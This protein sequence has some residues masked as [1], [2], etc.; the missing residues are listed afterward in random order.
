MDIFK[1]LKVIDLSTVLAGPSVATFFAELGAQ[2]IKIE[3]SKTADVTRSWKLP[4][5]EPNSTVSAYFSSV[6]YQKSYCSLDL[7]VEHDRNEFFNIVKDADLL[8]SNFKKGDEERLG[9]P[10]SIIRS[11]N[12]TLLWGKI[13][14]YGN[15]SDRVAYDLILQAETGYM[16]MNGEEDGLPV[17][18]PV[19]M[20]D[21]LAAH[22]LKEALLIAL[23]SREKTGEGS[24]VTVSLYDAA[25]SSLINQASNYLMESHIPQRLGSLHPN[26]AP[27]GELFLT[28]DD[29]WI[30]FAIGSDNHFQKLCDFLNISELVEDERFFSNHSRVKNR[31]ALAEFIQDKVKTK[32]ANQILEEMHFLHVPAASI[33]TLNEVFQDPQALKMVREE[34]IDGKDTK[35]VS[36]IAFKWISK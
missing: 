25:I 12:P 19:A 2:V 26:I 7:K 35:R 27:Y 21:V 28:K 32:T 8:I 34:K 16:S 31:V 11:I 20:I 30:T 4:S 5:E 15:E 17:K 24:T 3:N 10:E 22:Q 13:T 6:N 18:M 36:S 23:L 1:E 14:G 9:I 33:K 29:K